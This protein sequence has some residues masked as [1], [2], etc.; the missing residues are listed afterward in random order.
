MNG[1]EHKI[2]IRVME[3]LN[4]CVGTRH[5]HIDQHNRESQVL[6]HLERLFGGR[7]QEHLPVTIQKFTGFFEHV[8]IVID[9]KNHGAMIAYTHSM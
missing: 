8:G 2:W 9:N 1:D 4:E 3:L 7:S 6:D 5:I